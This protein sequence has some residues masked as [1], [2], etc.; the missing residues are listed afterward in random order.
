M[1]T[2][3]HKAYQRMGWGMAHESI[4]H[5]AY[6][7]ARDDI[8]TNS[9]ESFWV[10]LKGGYRGTYRKMSPKHLHRY[11]TEFVARHNLRGLSTMEQMAALA[12]GMIGQRLTYKATDREP[13]RRGDGRMSKNQEKQQECRRERMRRKKMWGDTTPPSNPEELAQAIFAY[14]PSKKKMG[15]Q[16]DR[17]TPGRTVSRQ[18]RTRPR[19]RNKGGNDQ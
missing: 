7:Y 9:I 5:G 14:G 6:E 2:D 8:H 19:Q 11:V 15:D 13:G 12:R 3:E 18:L 10:I 17:L 4:N 16:V 1:F